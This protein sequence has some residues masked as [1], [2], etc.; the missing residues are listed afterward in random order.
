MTADGEPLARPGICPHCSGIDLDKGATGMDSCRS[1]GGLS[2][3]GKPLRS[4]AAIVADTDR[5][6]AAIR[7]HEERSRERIRL[8]AEFA[9]SVIALD[10]IHGGQDVVIAALARRA[11]EV[12]AE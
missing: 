11:K 6:L 7:G 8:L 2:R 9:K 12:L 4:T 3:D 10:E 1:C 5:A